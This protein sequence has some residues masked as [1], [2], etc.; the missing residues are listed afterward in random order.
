MLPQLFD[1]E[2]KRIIILIVNFT[3]RLINPIV[4]QKKENQ[5]YTNLK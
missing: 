2:F 3:L 1:W 5:I 4:Y